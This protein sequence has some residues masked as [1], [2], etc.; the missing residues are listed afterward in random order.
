MIGRLDPQKGFDLLA[1]AAP[2]LLERGARLVVQGSGHPELADPFRAIAAANPDAGRVRRAVRPGDGPPDLRRR[3]L[4]RDAVALRAVR[5]GPDDRAALRHAA[6]RPSDRRTR[7]HGHRRGRPTRARGRASSSTG[8]TVAGLLAACDAA[9]APAR[10]RRTAR[11]TA[12]SI[13]GWRS[14]STGSRARR[15]ATSIAYRRGR[16]DLRRALVG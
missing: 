12:S 13:A 3:R 1:D 4:L 16:R 6:D 5:P 7:R 10:R 11:G 15:R 2:T 8:A 9:F 14:I